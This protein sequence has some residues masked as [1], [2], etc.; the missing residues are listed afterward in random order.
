MNGFKH[1]LTP[2]RAPA[3]SR[4]VARWPGAAPQSGCT[5]IGQRSA[6]YGRARA[7]AHPGTRSGFRAPTMAHVYSYSQAGSRH[8]RSFWTLQCPCLRFGVVRS[9]HVR[10]RQRR[11]AEKL[12]ATKRPFCRSLH[13]AKRQVRL[14]R[15]G[16]PKRQSR[17]ARACLRRANANQHRRAVLEGR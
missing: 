8:L 13:R 1:Y 11:V 14:P 10:E 4:A 5:E 2:R 3:L 16:R 6:L 9:Q 7:L 12:S 17:C 15:D